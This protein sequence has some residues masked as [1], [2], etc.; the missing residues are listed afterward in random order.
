MCD[1][2]EIEKGQHTFYCWLFVL[3][4]QMKHKCEAFLGCW[5]VE[6]MNVCPTLVTPWTVACQTPLSMEFSRQAYWSG[7]PF[8]SPGDGDHRKQASVHGADSRALRHMQIWPI[9]RKQS[10][11]SRSVRATIYQH[12][13]CTRPWSGWFTCRYSYIEILSPRV[14][15][16]G[17]GGGEWSGGD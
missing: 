9:D 8:S 12:P 11:P 2:C 5:G 7:L 4:C 17:S 16:L 3:N 13:L 14:M 15:A 6:K 1:F 10:Q